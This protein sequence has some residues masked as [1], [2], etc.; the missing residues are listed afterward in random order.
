M[1]TRQLKSLAPAQRFVVAGS[2]LDGEE[3][4]LF[5]AWPRLLAADPNLVLV[6]APRHPERF[7]AVA[8]LLD[9]SGLPWS[10]RSLWPSQPAAPLSP[11]AIVL[12]DTI[13]ELASIYSL[14]AVAFVGGSL[15]PAGGHNPLE[16]AQ[17][18][19]PIVM[20]PHYANFRAIA[21]DLLAHDALR[22]AAK[23]DLA[24]VLLDLLSNQPAAAAMGQRARQVFDQ[25][26]GATAPLRPCPAPTAHNGARLMSRLWL[27]PLVPLYAAAVALRARRIENGSQPI[28][29][30]LN[31]VVSIGNLSTGGSGK[32]PL[33]IALAQALTQRGLQVD[34]LSRGYGRR[35][36][37]PARVLPQGSADD[38]GDEPL[39]IARAAH[40]PV[41]VA[42]QRYDAGLLAESEFP[43]TQ[44]AIHLLDDG[45]QHRQLARDI[46][47]LL[48]NQNDLRDS[49]LPAGNLR[50][51]LQSIHRAHILA[52]PAG[53]PALEADLR[54]RGFQQP[55]WR[56]RRI[57]LVPPSDGPVLAF[58]GIARPQQ[59][60]AGLEASG[61]RLAV[62]TAFPDH[63]RYTPVDLDRLQTHARAAG[64]T[65][66]ITTEKDKVRLAHLDTSLPL[67]TA[68]LRIEIENEREAIDWLLHRIAPDPF[69]PPL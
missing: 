15:V 38:F 21:D 44:P 14:A 24:A 60:F 3:A 31:P 53:E 13:G 22:I 59:F 12:L 28:R 6:L 2:T 41:Y 54:A 34:V 45:F 52:L 37:L 36:R 9:A 48:L 33:T 4:A 20:G 58:C 63:F 56:L 66:L 8:A 10:R 39:L 11:G 5:E 1:A 27:A 67:K 29:R 25:Q 64:A 35:S 57:M 55:I 62:R 19:V 30:L 7:A 68:P 65:A 46:D 61:L 40:V 32:T 42:P 18:A 17:F 16:P 47:I 69:Q 26:S 50:E 23:D 49:L 51:P 43:S